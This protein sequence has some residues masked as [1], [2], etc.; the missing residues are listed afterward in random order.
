M[1]TETILFPSA[2]PASKLSACPSTKIP[3]ATDWIFQ[4]FFST[5]LDG[6]ASPSVKIS[7]LFPHEPLLHGKQVPFQAYQK[8]FSD[9]LIASW[10]EYSNVVSVEDDEEYYEDTP[11]LDN[12]K[13]SDEEDEGDEEF[14]QYVNMA[15]VLIESGISSCVTSTEQHPA[16]A[17]ITTSREQS[18]SKTVEQNTNASHLNQMLKKRKSTSSFSSL[19]SFMNVFHNNKKS[20]MNHALTSTPT[21]QLVTNTMTKKFLKYFKRA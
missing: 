10:F 8:T 16:V 9:D 17:K 3:Q 20:K 11:D 12:T 13:S 6:T 15:P 4:D 2:S 21:G 5:M 1:M 18:P 7:E 19:K 14:V